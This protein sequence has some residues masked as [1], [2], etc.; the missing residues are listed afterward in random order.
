MDFSLYDA[1]GLGVVRI[2]SCMLEVAFVVEWCT[3]HW[4]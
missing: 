3:I 2:E 1:V 4:S